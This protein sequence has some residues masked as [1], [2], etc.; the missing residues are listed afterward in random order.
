MTDTLRPTNRG[1]TMRDLKYYRILNNH[2]VTIEEIEILK[3]EYDLSEV[4]KVAIQ[5]KI[6]SLTQPVTEIDKTMTQEQLY[7]ANR[8]LWMKGISIQRIVDWLSLGPFEKYSDF[9]HYLDMVGHLENEIDYNLNDVEN[10]L[11]LYKKR[12][13]PL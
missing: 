10:S 1:D 13:K 3:K 2:H 11:K 6:T 8:P 9:E 12:D 7:L 4:I 5:L